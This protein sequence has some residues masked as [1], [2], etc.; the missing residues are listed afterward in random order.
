MPFSRNFRKKDVRH[1]K[2]A[3]AMTMIEVHL[4]KKWIAALPE[5]IE[6]ST[7]L[8]ALS[9]NDE[10]LSATISV[11]EDTLKQILAS[12]IEIPRR[13]LHRKYNT[14]DSIATCLSPSDVPIYFQFRLHELDD[15]I[16][17]LLGDHVFD[18]TA[19]KRGKASAEEGVLLIL[20]RLRNVSST[21]D[22]LEAFFGRSGPTLC[23]LF[24]MT[25]AEIYRRHRHRWSIQE[26]STNYVETQ[27]PFYNNLKLHFYTSF[28][29]SSYDYCLK[30]Q[31]FV[32]APVLLGKNSNFLARGGRYFGSQSSHMYKK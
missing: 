10:G 9:G 11:V 14:L 15:L 17:L 13:V 5:L 22:G 30:N 12:N 26:L 23:D 29:E 19:T 31:P 18:M 2:R 16:W 8:Q 1:R 25:I 20:C 7:M 4:A 28:Y 3:F 21:F 6:A 32:I 27:H 24:R